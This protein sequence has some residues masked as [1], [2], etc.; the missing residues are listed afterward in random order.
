MV[1]ERLCGSK[2]VPAAAGGPVERKSRGEVM[3][4]PADGSPQP[5]RN[6]AQVVENP[7]RGRLGNCAVAG[8]IAQG[9][10]FLTT[11]HSRY[12]LVSLWAGVPPWADPGAAVPKGRRRRKE[13]AT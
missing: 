12:L 2:L 5:Q 10:P 7:R 1:S 8:A 11:T 13:P 6:V 9:V 4:P 3:R